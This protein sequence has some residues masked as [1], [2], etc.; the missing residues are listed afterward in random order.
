MTSKSLEELQQENS[1]LNDRIRKAIEVF[2][3]QKNTISILTADKEALEAETLI[4][5][6]KIQAL[7]ESATKRSEN[8]GKFFDQ[9]QAITELEDAMAEM[10]SEHSRIEIQMRSDIKQR[11]EEISSLKST[12]DDRMKDLKS[13]VDVLSSVYKNAADT[14]KKIEKSMK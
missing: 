10:K 6:D 14:Y 1:R 12:V 11:D 3:E 5:K 4:L 13:M 8:D 9:L 7:E 2:T